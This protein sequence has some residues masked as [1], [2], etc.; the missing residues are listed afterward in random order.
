MAKKVLKV[1]E[2]HKIKSKELPK[3]IFAQAFSNVVKQAPQTNAKT[4]KNSSQLVPRPNPTPQQNPAPQQ[5]LQAHTSKIQSQSQTTSNPVGNMLGGL[6]GGGNKQA[7]GKQNNN[8]DA[9]IQNVINLVVAQHHRINAKELAKNAFAQAMSSVP[10]GQP[11]KKP[12]PKAS[13]GPAPGLQHLQNL[14]SHTKVS[15]NRITRSGGNSPQ[16]LKAPISFQPG[17]IPAQRNFNQ[18]K[19]QTQN[20]PNQLQKPVNNQNSVPMAKNPFFVVAQIQNNSNNNSMRPQVREASFYN[21]FSMIPPPKIQNNPYFVESHSVKPNQPGQQLKVNR[22]IVKKNNGQ[23][24]EIIEY[25]VIN[26]NNL[27]GTSGTSVGNDFQ[28]QNKKDQFNKSVAPP[29]P[30][31][32]NPYAMRPNDILLDNPAATKGFLPIL[33]S[34]K[35]AKI[36]DTVPSFMLTNREPEIIKICHKKGLQ[37]TDPEFKPSFESL[38]DFETQKKGNFNSEWRDYKWGRA[39]EVYSGD[40]FKIWNNVHPNDI[41]QGELGSCFLLSSL[42]ALAE[43]PALLT[44][45]FDVQEINNECVYAVWL[46][47]NGLWREIILDDY[48]PL[49]ETEKG[50]QFAFSRSHDDEMWVNLLEKA[51]AKAYGSFHRIDGGQTYEALKDLTGAPCEVY[52]NQALRNVDMIWKKVFEA[53]NKGFVI[54]AST[55]ASDV[56]EQKKTNGLISGHAY[57]V[58]AAKEVRDSQGKPARIVQIRNPWGS[59]EWNGDW[60]DN[61][62]KWTEALKNQLKVS[63]NDEGLFW[64]SIEDFCKTYQDVA[65]CKVHGN[66]YSNATQINCQGDKKTS[67][68]G[69][70]INVRTPGKYYIS[71]DQEDSRLY[72]IQNH[73]DSP[74]RLLLAKVNVQKGSL[75]FVGCKYG[76]RRNTHIEVDLTPGYYVA[77]ADV[78]WTQDYLRKFV[79]STYGPNLTGLEQSR[80]TLHEIETIQYLAWRDYA[81]KNHRIFGAGQERYINDGYLDV[82]LLKDYVD[83]SMEFGVEIK[84]Y[85]IKSGKGSVS[86]GFEGVEVQGYEII[87]EVNEGNRH[88]VN[89]GKSSCEIMLFKQQPNVSS[90]EMSYGLKPLEARLVQ[91]EPAENFSIVHKL[92]SPVVPL[93]SCN[94]PPQANPFLIGG[95]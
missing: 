8:I 83:K 93:P 70:T 56:R 77:I 24:E 53:D 5:N 48:F 84:R 86:A 15:P 30:F 19:V 9:G 59:H 4:N 95:K 82:T 36:S 79:L 75:D 52:E 60:S 22:K 31:G 33:G 74:S 57:S 29:Q 88:I 2:E 13:T 67:V 47:I 43:R 49:I 25:E 20:T 40:H 16:G 81:R 50:V 14:S 55:Y 69:I 34:S 73:R 92:A 44:R 12:S 62:T 45:L 85:F 51:Y 63:N 32:S 39:S 35:L 71:L 1:A 80:L 41:M 89:V 11:N 17:K 65:I 18:Q 64:M 90:G 78:Y 76:C 28:N 91:N 3:N 7:D 26:P 68:Q 58:I 38:V 27:E 42:S 61:S 66:Y 21:N 46:N 94:L 54:C 10:I 87:A 23:T 6:F 72:D 37:F